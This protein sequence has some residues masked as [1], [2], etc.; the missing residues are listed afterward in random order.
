MMSM[1][2]KHCIAPVAMA[3]LGVGSLF[4]TPALAQ[5]DK[6]KLAKKLAN[7]V[8]AL[9]SVP[10]QLNDDRNIGPDD[11]GERWT[12][13]PAGNP[14]LPGVTRDIPLYPVVNDDDPIVL[15]FPMQVKGKLEWRGQSID[16][17]ATADR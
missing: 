9:I 12:L 1:P 2:I 13:A 4:N 8:A 3:I 5:Q 10:F 15:A 14:I 11:T 7:P 6:S 17:D 16:I